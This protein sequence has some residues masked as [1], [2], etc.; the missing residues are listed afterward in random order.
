ME[1]TRLKNRILSV[2]L[3]LTMVFT[4]A[5]TNVSAM[6]ND[7]SVTLKSVT[8]PSTIDKGSPFSLRGKIKANEKIKSVSLG[9]VSKETRKWVIRYYKGD[10]NK[11]AFNIKKADPYIRFGQLDEGVY[12][13]RIYVKLPG[14]KGMRVLNKKFTVVD[15][16]AETVSIR[17]PESSA[18]KLKGVKAP[19]TYPVGKLFTPKGTVTAN[20]NISKVE[21]GIVFAGTNKWLQYKYTGK[22]FASKSFDLS[23][24]AKKL[25]FDKLPGGDYYY[26]MYVHTAD[27][28]KIAFNKSFTV[29]PSNKPKKAVKWAVK[30]ANNDDFSYGKKPKTS[31]VG[32]YFCGTNQKRKPKGYEKTYVCLTFVAAAYAHGAKDPEMLAECKEGNHTMLANEY[33]MKKYSC[34]QKIGL[35]RDLTVEDLQPGDVLVYYSADGVSNGH[36]AMY[37]GGNKM[38][39]AEG[40][41][42]CWGPNSIAVREK[43]ASMLASAARFNK[44]SFVMRYRF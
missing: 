9:I 2:L 10:I 31:K 8:S 37:V 21:V 11:K 26:R 42:D 13:Y 33:N 29:L 4:L 41:K 30:I 34:W 25:R 1:Q 27:G 35:A 14:K 39:D 15:N 24:A 22:P 12:Y 40:I 28:V 16:K 6:A 44:K 43:A 32:C 36:V 19:G 7:G 3:M 17:V 20:K 38:V 18:L 23:K 5:V